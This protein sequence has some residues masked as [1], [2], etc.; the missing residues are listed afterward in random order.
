MD[1]IEVRPLSLNM[2]YKGRRF[3]TQR[4]KDFKQE[5]WYLLPQMKIP[6]GKLKVTYVFGVSSKNSDGDNCIKAFQDILAEKYGFNDKIIYKWDVEK[7][8]VSKGSEFI[9]FK[10][11]AFK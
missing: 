2:A 6:K 4:L 3:A 7:R 5:V 9:E 11:T 10:I 1:K 8:D